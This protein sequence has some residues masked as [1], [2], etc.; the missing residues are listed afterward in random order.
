MSAYLELWQR[1]GPELVSLSGERCAI[2]KEKTNDIPLVADRSVSRMHAVLERLPAGWCIRDLSSRNGTFVNGERIFGERPLRPGDEI[3]VGRTR[4]V[5][6]TGVPAAATKTEAA[7]PAPEL[8][9]REH[10]VLLAL[11]RPLAAGDVFT[12]PASIREIAADLVVT[13][14]AVRQHLSRL[15]GK[16]SVYGDKDRLRVRLANEALRRGA[17]SLG[18]LRNPSGER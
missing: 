5:Y 1:S 2:G 10:E 12:E 4:I 18:D 8:T 13:E 6:R 17:V 7:E 9:R 15:Y 14:A 11:C 3:V 16:F